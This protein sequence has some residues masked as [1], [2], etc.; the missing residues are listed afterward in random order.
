MALIRDSKDVKATSFGGYSSPSASLAKQAAARAKETAARSSYSTAMQQLAKSPEYKASTKSSP[1]L[2]PQPTPTHSPQNGG[3]SSGSG[4]MSYDDAYGRAMADFNAQQAAQQAAYKSEQ[5][6]YRKALVESK[7]GAI[8]SEY[9]TNASIIKNNLTRALAALN[10]NKAALEPLYQRQLSSIAQNQFNT[11]ETTKEIMNQ[12]GWNASN[13]GLA[14]GEQTKIANTAD[15]QRSESLQAKTTAENEYNSQMATEQMAADESLGS[16]GLWRSNQLS[17]A[18]ADALVTSTNYGR[19]IYESDRDFAFTQ[20]QFEESVRQFEVQ[21]A[22]S[23]ASRTA[24]Q[25]AAV[26]KSTSD[27]SASSEY[28]K[29]LGALY[30]SNVVN[31]K[32]AEDLLETAISDPTIPDNIKEDMISQYYKWVTAYNVKQSNATPTGS[33]ISG[34]TPDY[35]TIG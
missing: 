20:K 10:Q 23:R 17:A 6:A 29:Y 24:S 21:L 19:A 26:A 1:A 3:G 35:S 34:I 11:S 9:E 7:K 5:E 12:G 32:E 18:E 13:S 28:S 25:K 16:L 2:S 27:G 4:K 30:S 15:T 8:N 33:T 22:E 14:V 31:P